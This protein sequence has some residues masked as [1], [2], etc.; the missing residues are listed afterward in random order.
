MAKSE[1]EIKEYRKK[2]RIENADKMREYRKKWRNEN[3]E[4]TKEIRE[5][6]NSTY[7]NEWR[8]Q[9]KESCYKK[10]LENLLDA[11]KSRHIKKSH[12]VC[13]ITL[14]DLINKYEEQKGLCAI[15][16]VKLEHKQGVL[17]SI[18]I[19]RIENTLGYTKDNVHLVAKWINIG[20]N[21]ATIDQIKQAIQDVIN[22]NNQAKP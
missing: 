6:R 22:A 13:E 17:N 1:Q 14:E 3:V 18:S 11:C 12:V 5:N 20:R 9:S 7:R 8:K 10:W 21:T 19:D 4:K 16:K 2:W 15:S